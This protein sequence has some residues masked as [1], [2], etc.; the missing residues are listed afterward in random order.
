MRLKTKYTDHFK[1]KKEI[2]CLLSIALLLNTK[3][4]PIINL[5]SHLST[6]WNIIR[7]IIF[8]FA[9]L[10]SL[11]TMTQRLQFLKPEARKKMVLFKK[12]TF[13]VGHSVSQQNA[14]GWKFPHL[15]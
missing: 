13:H 4:V 1:V 2:F 5:N 14:G 6:I 7:S 12:N 8:L 10:V 11:I 9:S 3:Y 15:K